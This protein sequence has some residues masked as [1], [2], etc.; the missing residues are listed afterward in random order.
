MIPLTSERNLCGHSVGGRRPFFLIAGPC[1]IE[2]ED[3]VMQV[4][5]ELVALR[6]RLKILIFFK[7]SFDKANRSSIRSYRGPGLEKGV[8]ILARVKAATGLPL[9]TDIHEPWQA[10]PVAKVVDMGQ[11][12][13]YLCRQTDLVV[14]AAR[15][16]KALNVKK[17]QFIAPG[18]ADKILE[19]V[20]E[21]GNNN[22]YLTERGYTFGY[23]N[24]IVDPRSFEI[25]RRQNIPVIF[26][27]TH[28]VQMPGGGLT[29]GGNRDMI[30]VQARAAVASGV[31]GLFF[32]VHPEP[33]KGLSDA[34]NM[35]HLDKLEGIIRSL[36]A[37]D[38]IVKSE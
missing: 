16:F 10:E 35:L 14:S 15:H 17:G 12:P 25:V 37:I 19:K 3:L 28:S 1:V 34:S 8:E 29:S 7:A 26:D 27:A 13:A 22:Y 9:V 4:A 31:E 36:L 33:E 24:L 2:S 30:F 20:Q 18:D 5:R 38:R 32:E 23:N 6:D 21:T 11:I